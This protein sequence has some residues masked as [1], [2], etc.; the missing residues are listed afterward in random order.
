MSHANSVDA[1]GR[2][3]WQINQWK[4][5]A[6]M[7]TC[8]DGP[9][10][11]ESA[12]LEAAESATSEAAESAT[13]EVARSNGQGTGL[14]AQWSDLSP[15]ECR[16]AQSRQVRPRGGAGAELGHCLGRRLTMLACMP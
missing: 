9:K 3:T 7:C 4:G 16:A 11:A 15:W 1:L 10:A 2:G 6:T 8:L 14:G 12:T 5:V 13:L